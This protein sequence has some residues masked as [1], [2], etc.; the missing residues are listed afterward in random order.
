M[1]GD[2]PLV[3]IIV[4]TKDRPKLLKRAIQSIASQT[5]KPVE[6]VLVND[7]GC[8]IDIEE[9]KTILGDLSL[10][11]IRLEHNTGRAHAGNLGM[12]HAQGRYIGFLD[13][14]DEFC[15]EHISTLISFLLQS[16]YKAAYTDSEIIYKE[17]NAETKKIT[18]IGQHIFSSKDFSYKDLLIENYIPLINI[19]FSKDALSVVGGF[20]E[21]LELYE[22]WDLLLRYGQRYPFYH[23]RM[24]TSKYIQWS[25]E[26][27]IAQSPEYWEKAQN[28]Y[29]QV[30]NKHKE[31]FTSEVLRYLRD[32]CHKL[33][34]ALLEKDNYTRSI[35]S[36]L[37]AQAAVTLNS[38][39]MAKNQDTL[40]EHLE[41]QMKKKDI[42]ITNLMNHVHMLEEDV[43]R[44]KAYI[45]FIHSGRGWKVLSKYYTIRDRMLN[46]FIKRG[47]YKRNNS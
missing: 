35:E 7:G 20:D 6:V 40:I 10:N 28:A 21:R 41:L 27:Q 9:L 23:I 42:Q 4:R 17:Y 2:N 47:K 25:K 8:D 3:S 16:D 36:D 30:I 19:L 33:K 14:D 24:V 34:A 15:R 22:D 39:T 44:N 12:A 26:L 46:V 45:N 43:E 37:K 11:Y 18:D 31:E 1:S 38:Q 5:Y 32:Y 13:D 29:D